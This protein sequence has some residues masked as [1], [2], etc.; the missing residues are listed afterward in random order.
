MC[1][2]TKNSKKVRE[3]FDY[4]NVMKILKNKK[5]LYNYKDDSSS[6]SI[7]KIINQELVPIKRLICLINML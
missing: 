5:A 6:L 1:L 4:F 3:F 7:V 2:K